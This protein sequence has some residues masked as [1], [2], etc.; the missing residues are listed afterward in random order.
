M[1]NMNRHFAGQWSPWLEFIVC[2]LCTVGNRS[3]QDFTSQESSDDHA[4]CTQYCKM[5]HFC[6]VTTGDKE[7]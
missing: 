3:M 5:G 7:V 6:L 2:K 4:V 1:S